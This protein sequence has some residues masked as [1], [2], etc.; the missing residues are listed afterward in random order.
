MAIGSVSLTICVKLKAGRRRVGQLRRNI[1]DAV[2]CTPVSHGPM[3]RQE[4][5]GSSPF[6]V[7]IRRPIVAT[8]NSH[9][10]RQCSIACL[11]LLSSRRA[12]GCDSRDWRT[13]PRSRRRRSV[14]EGQG[15]RETDFPTQEGL[16]L[17][18]NT[19]LQLDPPNSHNITA[20]VQLWHQI[21]SAYFNPPA[22]LPSRVR[23]LQQG[24]GV[25]AISLANPTRGHARAGRASCQSLAQPGWGPMTKRPP[26]SQSSVV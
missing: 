1:P 25:S 8:D 16:D 5:A 20:T 18:K 10:G 14:A 19:R 13:F 24:A 9:V 6:Q 11:S 4:G 12:S 2:H 26:I 7:V 21:S 3:P 22:Q 17:L 23:H 15:N